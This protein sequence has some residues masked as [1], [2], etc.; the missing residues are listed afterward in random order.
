MLSTRAA[1][2][3]AQLDIP[4][5]F[6]PAARDLFDAESNPEGI[7]S[8]AKAENPLMYDDLAEFSSKVEFPPASFTYGYSSF[9]GPRLA[10]ALA[11]HVNETFKPFSSIFPS[12]IQIVNGA[13]SLHSILAFSLAEQGD[14]ILAPRPVYGRF[15][16]DL[17]NAMGVKVVYADSASVEALEPSVVVHCEEA[18]QKAKVGGINVK[19]VLVVNPSNPLGRCYPRETL[20]GLLELCQRHQLHLISDEVYGL[21]VFGPGTDSS[22][23][24]HPFTSVLSIDLTDLIDPNLVHVEYGTSKDFAA[25]GLRLGALITKNRELQRSVQAV[26][27]FHE[28]SG[29]S[30]AIGTAMF[31]DREWCRAFIL[32]AR[33]RIGDA[34]KFVTSRLSEIGIS[35]LEANAGYF[36]LIDLA[37]WLPPKGQVYDTTQKRE[38]ALAEK[39][40]AGGVFLHPGEEHALE[41]GK[42]R[43]VYTQQRPVITEGL[44]RLDAVLKSVDWSV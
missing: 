42:F 2:T 35:Y 10:A 40:V 4:W 11:T 6:T 25:A 29:M 24:L 33:A 14:A 39:L 36:V 16:L 30:V 41:A 37:P 22:R 19:A 17:G 15:E 12:D 1:T 44:K 27:R 23:G 32:N 21:S 34:Y 8:L 28:P 9:G 20:V 38:F 5:R 7:I 43:L 31:E 26:G 3:L 13:T 18:L